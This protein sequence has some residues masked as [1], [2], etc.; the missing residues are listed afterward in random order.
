MLEAAKREADSFTSIIS[1]DSP[2]SR[3]K[4]RQGEPAAGPR[5]I[6]P[7]SM[8]LVFHIAIKTARKKDGLFWSLKTFL[9]PSPPQNR[10]LGNCYLF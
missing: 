6:Q 2:N 10:E 7:K 3:E 1:S 4:G 8:Q 9:L 5:S